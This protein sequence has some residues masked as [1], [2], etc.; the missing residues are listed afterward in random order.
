MVTV[1]GFAFPLTL[2]PPLAVRTPLF[3]LLTHAS[4]RQRYPYTPQTKG[5]VE[6][7]VGVLKAGFWPGVRFTDLDDLNAQVLGW[8]ERLNGQPHATTR[9]APRVRWSEEHLRPLPTDWA[10]E[11][12]AAEERRVSWDGYI[13]YDG[14]LYDGVLYDGVLYGLPATLPGQPARVGATVQVRERGGQLAIWSGGERIL[15]VAKHARSRAV[16]PHPEQFRGVAP[17][18]AASRATIPLGHRIPA[19]VVALRD[20]GEYDRLCGAARREVRQ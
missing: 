3:L 1:M 11:R 18:A 4:L 20:L 2:P 12:F 6:R 5:K 16:V 15:V 7:T 9:V 8:C 19:P 14:V 10:W 17:A 13:S